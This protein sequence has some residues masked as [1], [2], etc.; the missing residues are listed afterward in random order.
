MTTTA[1]RLQAEQN[2]E[3]EKLQERYDAIG[4][5]FLINPFT[6][7]KWDEMADEYTALCVSINSLSKQLGL[8]TN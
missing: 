1:K 7:A 6:H 5:W 3:L 2:I 8:P 4:D